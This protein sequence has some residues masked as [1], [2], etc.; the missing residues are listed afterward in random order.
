MHDAEIVAFLSEILVKEGMEDADDEDYASYAE[1]M[2]KASRDIV[3]AVKLSNH[4]A[5]RKA[6][7]EISKACTECHEGYRG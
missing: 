7:G 3:D 1:R 2:K 5:A 6:V 4:E